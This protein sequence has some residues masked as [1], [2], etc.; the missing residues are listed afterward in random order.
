MSV[1][2]R[3][4]IDQKLCEPFDA[5]KNNNQLSNSLKTKLR[6]QPLLYINNLTKWQ[7]F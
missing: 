1:T 2:R 7:A 3:S 4:Y 6:R 5:V